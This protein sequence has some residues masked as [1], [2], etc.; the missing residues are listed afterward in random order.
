M[1]AAI[2]RQILR[3]THAAAASAPA[4]RLLRNLG[5]VTGDGDFLIRLLAHGLV[6]IQLLLVE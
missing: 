4:T 6:E 3:V 1:L 2:S 5:F